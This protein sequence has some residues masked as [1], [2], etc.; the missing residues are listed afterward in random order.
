MHYRTIKDYAIKGSNLNSKNYLP[1]L[2]ACFYFFTFRKI[3]PMKLFTISI[4]AASLLFACNNEKEQT[5]EPK[6]AA[7]ATTTPSTPVESMPDSATMMK[8]WE[9]YMTPGEA[10]QMM[11]SWNGTWTGEVTMWMTADAPPS[12]SR[13]TAVNKMVLG[14]RYQQTTIKGNFN[15]MPFEGMSTLAFDNEKKVYIS[16][17]IDNM[18]TGLMVSQGPWDAA[19]KSIT[20][21]GRMVDPATRKEVEFK[22][23]FKPIDNNYQV[24]EMY[25]T[26]PDGKE[27]KTMEI[28][29]TR[30]N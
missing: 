2:Q 6:V 1:S 7:A 30:K 17:W 27:F 25:A 26:G 29:Y 13:A 22:E 3:Y 16:T 23:I 12:K 5:A 11:A 14:G 10:H 19:S 8:N 24:M 9:A 18:G 4:C 21:T 28:K 20:F 15:G